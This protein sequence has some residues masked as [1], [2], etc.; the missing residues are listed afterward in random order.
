MSEFGE[1]P[2]QVAESH[3]RSV[4]M[5]FGGTS[6]EDAAAIRRAAQIVKLRLHHKPVVVVSALSDVTDH[7]LEMGK[8]AARGELQAA[9]EALENLHQRHL[10]VVL[11][12]VG[13]AASE[14][15]LPLLESDVRQLRLLL[16]NISGAG[17]LTPRLQ[18]HLLGLGECLASRI[19][20][21]AFVQ[22]GLAAVWVDARACIMTDSAHTQATPLWEETNQQ[23]RAALVPLLADD[24]VPLL[25]GFIGSTR[26][27][28]PTTLGRGGSDYTASII[29]AALQAARIEIWTDVDGIL[30]TDPKLCPD[31][32]RVPA[33]SFE[34]AADLAY[35][36]AKILHPAAIAPAM[37]RNVPVWVVNSRNPE[38][39]GTE[40]VAHPG[41]ECSIKAITAKKG[42]TVVD[43]EAVRWFA[44]ELLREIFDV[45][46]RH[47]YGLDFLS[48]SRGSLSLLVTSTTALP[49]ITEELKGLANVRWESEKALVCLVGEKVRRQPEIASQ[50]FRALSDVDLRMI[51]HGASER[52]ISFLLDESQAE[53]S[54][55][56]LHRLFFQSRFDRY[57]ATN[58]AQPMCQ[59]GG[60]WQ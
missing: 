18:D 41:D 37:R 11:D 21:A 13:P 59:A 26:D 29:G 56:R 34:E 20:Q 1:Q 50:V 44:P 60:T 40:I 43:V 6:V 57:S 16:K 30:T 8:T 31:A 45:F 27:G 51:C 2:N 52:N 9:N 36:G 42:I 22:A 55:R 58:A 4:V 54:V 38:G 12:A 7:L 49:A 23:L 5:K 25:G 28:I 15:L 47:Q 53:E 17:E 46:E 39:K 10:L 48:A 24:K 33:M 14:P 3:P 19:V 35:F 32:R